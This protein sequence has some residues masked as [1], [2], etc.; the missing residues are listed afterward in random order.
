MIDSLRAASPTG[1][2]TCS[3]PLS[4]PR[5]TS[6]ALIAASRPGSA[7]PARDAIPQIPHIART[8]R[9]HGA[10]GGSLPC[11]ALERRGGGLSVHT[12]PDEPGL[13]PCEA[14]LVDELEVEECTDA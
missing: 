2:S 10:T 7:A 9:T 5:W 11:G 1:P 13:P 14:R 12:A 4:G 6:A 8:L 3:P